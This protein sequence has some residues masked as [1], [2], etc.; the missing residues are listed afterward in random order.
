M[1]VEAQLLDAE[2]NSASKTMR[3]DAD[4][5]LNEWY[6]QRDNVYFALLEQEIKSPH[7]WSAE[8]PYLYTLILTLKDKDGIAIDTRSQKVGFRDVSIHGN[9]ML[10]NGKKVKL[11]GVNRHD[12]DHIRGKALTREDMEEDI[13]L[14]KRY[15]LNAIRT[16]HYPNDPYIYDLCDQYGIYVMDEA[17]LETHAVRGLLSNQPTWAAA[18]LD[19]A[20][21]MVERDKNHPSI[22]SWSLGNES[23]SGPNH[24]AMA[25]WIKDY[26]DTRFIHYEGAQ[27]NKH[28]PHYK[29]VGSKEYKE[30]ESVHGANPTDM[31]YVD[32][33]SRM[34]PTLEVLNHMA[35]DPFI[36][37]P[38]MMCEYAHAMGNSLGN[39][40]EYW[41]IIHTHD[42]ILG[43]FIWDW[44]D[45]GILE[46]DENGR[47]YYAVGG[48]YG[49]KVNAG[50]FC[51]NGII[52]SDRTPKPQIEECKY[53][54][55]PITF[56]A[57]DLAKGKIRIKNRQ[58]FN[59][60]H[61]MEFKWTLSQDGKVIERGTLSDIMISPE[62]FMEVTVPFRT[63]K[64]IIGAEYWL[65]I[66]A[67]STSIN[68]GLRK[69]TK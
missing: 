21:R 63:P 32:V 56:E 67:H 38:I 11:Y 33:I 12:H 54:Y 19:R 46:Q 60:T 14:L 26:D 44:I 43:G 1:R 3:M 5:I 58:W 18:Y 22:I 23:G 37:R 57:I 64:L 24:A 69:D 41:D 65:R 17:N 39:M 13:K 4:K 48:D 7:K 30:Y 29:K 31:P 15:N 2:G 49:D 20:I 6:P 47:P 55:Q 10:I 35:N 59:N 51:L 68:N 34:Y 27:G 28:H 9:V 16:S 45:Q 50:N 62:D 53:I 66:S 61:N 40:K 52:A 25:A 8:N 42:N 36:Q